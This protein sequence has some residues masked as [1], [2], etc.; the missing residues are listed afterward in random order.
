MSSEDDEVL[1]LGDDGTFEIKPKIVT[2]PQPKEYEKIKIDINNSHISSTSSSNVLKNI[3]NGEFK[4]WKCSNEQLLVIVNLTENKSI[5][6]IRINNKIVV[7]ET[8]TEELIKISFPLEVDP[9]KHFKIKIFEN[10]VALSIA[11]AK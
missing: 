4:I 9:K 8:N 7:I 3:P 6:S 1:E 5:T 2:K 11:L 10:Y